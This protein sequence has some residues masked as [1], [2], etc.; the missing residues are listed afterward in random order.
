MPVKG[1]S[2]ILL[3]RELTAIDVT[4]FFS[5]LLLPPNELVIKGLKQ[6]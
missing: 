3:E 2:T 6:D 5:E 1:M 4:H